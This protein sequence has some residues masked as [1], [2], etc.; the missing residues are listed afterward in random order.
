VF[1]SGATGPAKGVRYTHA[2]LAAQR[3]ALAALFD[4]TPDDRFVAAFA[5]FSVFGPALGITSAI[6]DCDVTTPGKLTAAVLDAA[7]AAVD[8]TMVFASPAALA[9]VVATAG[10]THPALTR[11]RLV[12]SAGAPVPVR[13]LEAMARLAP[14]AVLHTPYGMTECLP[15]ASFD[16]DGILAAG[17]GAG[18]C[19]GVPV[20]G[21]DVVIDASEILVSAPWCSAGYDRL[22][23]T[24]QH[25]RPDRGDGKVWHRTGDVGHLDVDGRLWVEGRLVHV[26]HTVAGPVTPVPVEVAVEAAVGVA[27]SAA[28]GVG[29][30]GVQQLVVVLEQPGRPGLADDATTRAVRAKVPHPVAAVLQRPALPVDIRHNAKIDRTALAEWADRVLAGGRP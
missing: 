4:V 15:V 9:N 3:D 23:A 26:I 20:P 25:A 11:L 24:E 30:M 14:V 27:R 13:T 10:A 19:V 22:W 28:V 2:Q 1:T 5:P 7:C 17:A 29:P 12:M 18:V 21:C 6:P 16:L 8:A